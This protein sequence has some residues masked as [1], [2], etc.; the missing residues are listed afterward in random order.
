MEE[1]PKETKV[2]K[3]IPA[4]EGISIGKVFLIEEEEV[5]IISKKISKEQVKK[6]I[7]RYNTALSEVKKEMESTR[8]KMLNI[9]GK[10]HTPLCDAYLGM[11]DDPLL[12]KDVIRRIT[13]DNINAEYAIWTTLEKVIK[14]FDNI[15]D[16]YFR[17]RKND[18]Q[19]LG[20]R[21]INHL[22]GKQRRKITD[23]EK[24]SIIIAHNLNPTDTISLKEHKVGGFAINIGGRTSHIALIAEGLGIPA[25]VGLKNITSE[26]NNGDLV[27]LD[28]NQ[29]IIIINPDKQTLENYTRELEIQL[30]EKEELEKLRNLPAETLDGYRVGLQCNIDTKEELSSVITSGAE[31]IGLFRTEFLYLNRQHLPSED[32]QYEIYRDILQKTLPYSVTIRTLDLG[33]DKLAQFGLEEDMIFEE[34]NP[35]LGLRA[36]RL[37]LKYPE[38]L[39]KPQLRAILRASVAGKARIIFPMISSAE[40]FR[41]AKE[42]F[43]EVK[44]ELRKENQPYDD[45]IEIGA[46]IEIPSAALTSDIIA[47]DADFLSIGTNDLIQYTLAVDRLNEN[48]AFMYEPL[49]L[50]ILRLLKHIIDSA[51]KEGK[52]VAMCGEMAADMEFTK[53]L[54]GMGLNEFSVPV[55][56]IPKIKKVIRT[57]TL[58][59]AKELVREVLGAESRESMIKAFRKSK[60]V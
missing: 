14:S 35:F 28:G 54:L 29:G 53:L 26:V 15:D 49:H 37:C 40:E 59:E 10:Q 55:H 39:F 27:I 11:L 42:I 18:I 2:I 38:K 24:D 16:E 57:T 17:E 4:S 12:N 30:R 46:M 48:I 36:I 22:L 31:G 56:M 60:V 9:L 23:A 3:G 50:S 20:R 7:A 8:E 44:T 33:G 41:Q 52:P 32:E 21:I 34:S 43:E 1:S 45:T 51:H 25:I 5:A 13:E 47:R 6:E 58:K 19:E